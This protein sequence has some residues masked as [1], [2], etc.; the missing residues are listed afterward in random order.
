MSE[1]ESVVLG[2]C[3]DEMVFASFICSNES[4]LECSVLVL[5]FDSIVDIMA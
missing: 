1:F 4:L 5:V 3:I 2:Q